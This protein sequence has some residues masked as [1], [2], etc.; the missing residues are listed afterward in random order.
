MQKK[1]NLLQKV[2]IDENIVC[3]VSTLSDNILREYTL[4]DVLTAGY[5]IK[6]YE[7]DIRKC[8][9]LLRR[10]YGRLNPYA[11]DTA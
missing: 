7:V 1:R 3:C 8:L 10:K 6:Y 2:T 11:V 5:G 9:S 4:S